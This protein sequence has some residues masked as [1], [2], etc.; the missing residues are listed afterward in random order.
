MPMITY[1]EAL[2]QGLREE[3]ARDERVLVFGEDVVAYGGAYG[4]TSGLVQEFGEK[5]VMDSPIAEG[6]IG[7]TAVGAAMGGLRP[8][9][10]LMTIN[11][12]LLASDAIINHAAKIR[13]MFG[14]QMSVPLVFR[15][16]GGA[17]AQLAATHSQNLESIFAHVPGLKVV[18]PAMPADAKGLLKSAIRDE[19]PVLF[20]E[21]ALLY[22]VRGEV[23]EGEFLIPMGKAEVKRAGKDITLVAYSRMTLVAL[24]AADR[25]SHEGIDAEVVDLRTLRPLDMETV[26]ASVRKTNRA[27]T[28][29]EAWRSYGI[30][31]EVASRIQ[32]EAFDHLDAP[33]QRVAAVEVPMPY[34]KNLEQAAI[35]N[36]GGVVEAVKKL[37]VRTGV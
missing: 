7:G 35:P 2:N 37:M 28:V 10:E 14:G 33:I 16:V 21:H 3:M 6:G 11:F 4:V 17:G 36:A 8:V 22:R 15:T 32:E 13:H 31:A 30:G 24:E 26:V 19:D 34:A 1:R 18:A 5:R 23:P 25:L 9:A 27:V 12:A 20:I 29:E